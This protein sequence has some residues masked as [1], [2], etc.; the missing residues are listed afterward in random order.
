L[1][2]SFLQ[3]KSLDSDRL[4]SL[5]NNMSDAVIALDKDLKVTHYNASTL[6]L[7]D[8]NTSIE[9]MTIDKVMYLIGKDDKSYNLKELIKSLKVSYNSSD[10]KLIY[11]EDNSSINIYLSI[12][13]VHMGY[14][15]EEGGYVISFR[16]I[17]REK[18]L[19]DERDEF[20]SVVSHELRNPIAIAEGNLSN[21][22]Y[23][24]TNKHSL[25][26]LQNEIDQS[27]KQIIFLSEL[28]NDLT[29]LARAENNKDPGKI[30]KFNPSELIQELANEFS[31]KAEEKK[32]KI[33]A[34]PDPNL[35]LLHSSRLY[36]KEILQ[37]FVTN[38]IKYTESGG[39][40]IVAKK[41]KDG[42]EFSVSDTGIGI[43]KA[44]SVKVFNKFFRSGDYRTSKSTGTGLGLYI[45][46]KLSKILKSTIT[47]ESV[48]NHGST[49]K[50]LVPDQ[51]T[52]KS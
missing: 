52:A 51:K 49:F 39:V 48:L 31:S 46:M 20:I 27:H 2:K 23:S 6:S 38:A 43:S 33:F 16:D 4:L 3:S 13:P 37:N 28:I 7:L 26:E 50:L 40:E 47:F 24:I 41:T 42:V 21:A 32:L 9:D 34:K 15:R 17:T 18:S 29:S 30:D 36:V 19:D 22:L 1:D 44:D 11:P 8:R 12:A 35:E 45:A 25:D 5:I 10:F 14:G